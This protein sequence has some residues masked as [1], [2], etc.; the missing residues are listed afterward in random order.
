M[1]KFGSVL[2]ATRTGQNDATAAGRGRGRGRGANGMKTFARGRGGAPARGRGR[3]QQ[4]S[5]P[6]ASTTGTAL[7]AGAFAGTASF[8]SPFAQ[9]KNNNGFLSANGSSAPLMFGKPS[10]TPESKPFTGFG[11][12]S[13]MPTAI[14]TNVDHTRD[15][16]PDAAS[17]RPVH[18]KPTPAPHS[19]G[20]GK[21][22]DYQGRYEK[23]LANS[24]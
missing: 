4:S 6:A 16:R 13:V 10:P 8:N 17:K 14:E 24:P 11:A 22:I 9:I 20:G 7:G 19:N 12:P 18:K 3:G 23:V 5:E 21:P 1:P 2:G 15:P